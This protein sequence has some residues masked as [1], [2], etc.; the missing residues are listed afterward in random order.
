MSS[1]LTGFTRDSIVTLRMIVL[2]ITPGQEPR[3]RTMMV[4]FMVVNLPSA[5]N[6]IIDRPTLNR[7][8]AVVSTY[9]RAMKF[10]TRVGSEEVRSDPLES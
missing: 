5:Y 6:V 8:R 1:T 2:P 4:A 9:H 7:L 3:S 10:P